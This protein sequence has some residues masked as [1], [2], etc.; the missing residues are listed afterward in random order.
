MV[1]GH[2][3]EILILNFLN[4]YTLFSVILFVF[5][6]ALAVCCLLGS[7]C[8]MRVSEVKEKSKKNPLFAISFTAMITILYLIFCV[9]QVVF[10]FAKKGVCRREL[11]T[12]NTPVRDFFSCWQS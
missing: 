9:V 5:F 11:P 7:I 8:S 12:L 1:F 4:P 6:S 3:M 2:M 10:L